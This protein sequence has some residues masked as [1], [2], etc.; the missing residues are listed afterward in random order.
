MNSKQASEPIVSHCREIN[1]ALNDTDIDGLLRRSLAKPT[2]PPTT[3]YIPSPHSFAFLVT[4][5]FLSSPFFAPSPIRLTDSTPFLDYMNLSFSALPFDSLTSS[6]THS[7]L[8]HSNAHSDS[9]FLLSGLLYFVPDERFI[10]FNVS[11]TVSQFSCRFSTS[12]RINQNPISRSIAFR[13]VVGGKNGEMA[14]N[15]FIT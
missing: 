10:P 2:R 7:F 6:T 8:V 14:S 3:P 13:V 12:H 15:W 9:I 4:R 1:A 5:L 11:R